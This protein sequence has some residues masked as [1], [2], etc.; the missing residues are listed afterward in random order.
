MVLVMFL[1]MNLRVW[2]IGPGIYT[3]S[4][5]DFL[6]YVIVLPAALIFTPLGGFM[7]KVFLVSCTPDGQI[8]QLVTQGKSNK[9]KKTPALALT[10]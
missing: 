3:N 2:L 9:K 1:T 8:N 6:P 7:R 5:P 4:L 10:P